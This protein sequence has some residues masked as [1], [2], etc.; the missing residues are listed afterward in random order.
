MPIFG[1]IRWFHMLNKNDS[2]T[3]LLDKYSKYELQSMFTVCGSMLDGKRV[4]TAFKCF[5]DYLI[6]IENID[7][8]YHCYYEVIFGEYACKPHFD[9]DMPSNDIVT[10]EYSDK[11]MKNVVSC[12]IEC[13][14]T[15]YK[16]KISPSKDIRIY[17][18]HGPKKFSYHVIVNNYCH[19]NATQSKA[20]YT[21][22]YELVDDEYKQ[23]KFID[24]SV[25]S[26]VQ[27]FRLLGSRK[28]NSDRVKIFHDG[29]NFNGM[30]I[31][32]EYSE[33]LDT[34]DD[35][36]NVVCKT[37]KKIVEMQESLIGFTCGCICVADVVNTRALKPMDINDNMVNKAL[38]LCEN[39]FKFNFEDT[40][41][42]YSFRSVNSGFIT[43]K[44]NKPTYCNICSVIHDN[45]NPFIVIVDNCAYFSCR[46]KEKHK[47]FLGYI[48]E[49]EPLEVVN[50]VDIND[51]MNSCS[52][53]SIKGKKHKHYDCIDDKVIDR[54]NNKL[55]SSYIDNIGKRNW[56]MQT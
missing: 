29:W 54:I 9:I 44:R 20:F 13:F 38:K 51:I 11:C 25:Y 55:A 18:S 27:Q 3:G 52:K 47:E 5:Q 2:K 15:L 35:S 23:S 34:I 1:G 17:S 26:S 36:E 32:C 6:Y 37:H 7:D 49:I 24:N 50:K 41:A 40:D 28:L 42:M 22:V 10:L 53:M 14:L 30:T 46:R 21:K 12:I 19:S 4:F 8:K 43:L 45:E 16:I 56:I 31:K 33:K 39:A 48:K